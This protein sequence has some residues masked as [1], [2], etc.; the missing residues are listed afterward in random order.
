TPATAA[1]SKP[2]T[3]RQTLI[4]CLGIVPGAI[5]LGAASIYYWKR[6][7]PWERL[8]PR[9]TAAEEERREEFRRRRQRGDGQAGEGQ[10]RAEGRRGGGPPGGPR[11]G[12][13]GKGNGK[14]EGAAPMQ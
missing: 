5:L 2:P 7:L 11:G 4:I 8:K 1:P 6:P 12:E 10:P 3:R 13:G 9:D 14:A